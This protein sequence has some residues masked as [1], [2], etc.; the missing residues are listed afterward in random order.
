VPREHNQ[1]FCS[2]E[3]L[4]DHIGLGE[5]PNGSTHLYRYFDQDGNLLYVGISISA[6]LRHLQHRTSSHWFHKANNM[7][8]ETY[9]TRAEAAVAEID[10]IKAERPLYNIA[11]NER[12]SATAVVCKGCNAR[13]AGIWRGQLWCSRECREQHQR[14]QRLMRAA[15]PDK[16]A[17]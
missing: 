1:A 4:C 14:A 13:F 15:T 16:L 2:E 6:L 5:R 9:E 12:E 8:W 10:A 11:H 17:A 7:T 3:C